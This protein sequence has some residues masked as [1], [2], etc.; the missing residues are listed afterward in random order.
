MVLST[1]SYYLYYS[2]ELLKRY[3]DMCE[4][5][6]NYIF[7]NDLQQIDN[8]L[9]SVYKHPYSD[10]IEYIDDQVNI[11]FSRYASE[12]CY[13][14]DKRVETELKKVLKK[15]NISADENIVSFL[16]MRFG[17]RGMRNLYKGTTTCHNNH[18]PKIEGF[19]VLNTNTQSDMYMFNEKIDI[20]N[21]DF[22]T[23]LNCVVVQSQKA[24]EFAMSFNNVDDIMSKISERGY[25]AII[26]LDKTN[27]DILRMR[28]G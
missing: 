11:Y 9:E 10:I 16:R 18:L 3:K 1:P 23:F 19:T 15:F 5:N 4:N 8:I 22:V 28:Y 20:L 27:N 12:S 6:K 21:Y 17:S 7:G 24:F 25:N 13:D 14:I 2:P 26:C